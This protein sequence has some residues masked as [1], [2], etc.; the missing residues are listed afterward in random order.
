MWLGVWFYVC[1]L[2]TELIDFSVFRGLWYNVVNQCLIKEAKYGKILTANGKILQE[3]DS[4]T[5]GQQ[6]LS[7]SAQGIISLEFVHLNSV[8]KN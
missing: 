7:Q 4:F 3:Y 6:I 5:I 8:Q 2:V 1:F